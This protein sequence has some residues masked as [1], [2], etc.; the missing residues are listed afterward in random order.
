MSAVQWNAKAAFEVT[1]VSAVNDLRNIKK[2]RQ[3]DG[4]YDHYKKWII[5]PLQKAMEQVK[6]VNPPGNS[7]IGY[8]DRIP[9]SEAMTIAENL[10]DEFRKVLKS[11]N[12]S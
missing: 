7:L 3:T 4:S 2:A 6:A 9:L 5:H 11:V 12:R 1:F 8:G 10:P